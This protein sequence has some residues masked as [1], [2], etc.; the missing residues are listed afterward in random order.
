MSPTAVYKAVTQHPVPLVPVQSIIGVE[1]QG[2]DI[3][4][5]P[6]TEDADRRCDDDNDQRYHIRNTSF[7]ANISLFAIF[8]L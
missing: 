5:P 1:L 3:E 6:E 8:P 2:I 7:Y 4:H